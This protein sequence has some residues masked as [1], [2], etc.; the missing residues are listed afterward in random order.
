MCCD[1]CRRE[2][3][4]LGCVWV[5]NFWG[6]FGDMEKKAKWQKTRA[7]AAS[8]EIRDAPTSGSS[9]KLGRTQE[10][11]SALFPEEVLLLPRGIHS[12]GF[13]EG[14]LTAWWLMG[15]L[16]QGSTRQL[17]TSS[18]SREGSRREMGLLPP[19]SHSLP[20]RAG[21]GPAR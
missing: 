18:G 17:R 2:R 10:F 9:A 15:K 19:L 14:M 21:L 6:P 4:G 13:P 8:V 7:S 16:T 11:V 3:A 1:G 5:R 20:P 12:R